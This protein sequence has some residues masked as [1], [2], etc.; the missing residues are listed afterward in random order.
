MIELDEN[1][2]PEITSR[3]RYLNP[4]AMPTALMP[5]L[6]IKDSFYILVNGKAKIT[7]ASSSTFVERFRPLHMSLKERNHRA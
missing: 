4:T 7:T 3:H 1:E 5:F 2:Q 6:A